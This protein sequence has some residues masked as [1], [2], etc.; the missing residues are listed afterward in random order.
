MQFYQISFA[1]TDHVKTSF[2]INRTFVALQPI[3][4]FLQTLGCLKEIWKRYIQASVASFDFH[5]TNQHKPKEKQRI[6]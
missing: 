1:K 3:K 6:P 5:L 4:N 2:T